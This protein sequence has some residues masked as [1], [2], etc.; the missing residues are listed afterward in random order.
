LHRT[1]YTIHHT[2]YTIH[3]Y[4]HTPIHPYTLPH[5]IHPYTTP[6]HPY[7]T[8][9]TPYTIHHTPIHPY[10]HTPIHP[11]TTHHTP[12]YNTHTPIYNTPHTTHHAPY[13]IHSYASLHTSHSQVLE[14]TGKAEEGKVQVK[15]ST[16]KRDW[17]D[18]EQLHILIVNGQTAEQA[19]DVYFSENLCQVSIV[20][21]V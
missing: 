18:Q 17:I 11:Y 1:P 5:I 12:I 9:H 8:H 10:T 2:P 6:I 21:G 16:G 7:T 4:T 3:P 20:Y 13:T 15:Y 19:R 14:P